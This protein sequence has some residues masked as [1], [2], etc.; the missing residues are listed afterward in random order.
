MLAFIL[1]SVSFCWAP[2]AALEGRTGARAALVTGSA[3]P[4]LLD[5]ET[6]KLDLVIAEMSKKSPWAR[7]VAVIEPLATRRAGEEEIALSPIARNGENRW[8]MTLEQTVRDLDN[9]P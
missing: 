7:D 1:A 9:R 2:Q 5:L 3:E 6:G 4:L 8:V